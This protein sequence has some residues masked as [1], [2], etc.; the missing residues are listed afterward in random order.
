VRILLTTDAMGGVWDHATTLYGRLAE[1]GHDVFLAVLGRPSGERT[2]GLPAGAR[3]AA[4]SFALE[5]A[6]GGIQDIEPAARWIASL[7]D[8]MEADV[9]HLNQ[10]AYAHRIERPT[11]VAVHSDAWSWFS[12]IRGVPPRHEPRWQ[13][14]HSAVARG[15]AAAAA[16][17]AP[18][19]YQADRVERHYGRAVD[20]VIRNGLD[21]QTLAD[22]HR[23][24]NGDE[25]AQARRLVTLGRA[26]DEA[27]GHRTVDEALGLVRQPWSA[28]L[29]GD[30]EGPDG[31]RLH[32]KRLRY[33]G[34]LPI[35]DARE[36]LRRTTVYVAAS[37]YEPFGLAPV[38]AAMA[39]CAL[40]LSDIGSFRELWGNDALFFA[41]GNAAAL[42]SVLDRLHGDRSLHHQMRLQ[43]MRRA[44]ACFDDRRMTTEYTEVY[45]A[46]RRRFGLSCSPAPGS[47]AS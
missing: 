32:P 3:W 37:L 23:F 46:V 21:R 9:V 35:R 11:V 5:W 43:A 30:I 34:R 26:W 12:E 16:V 27:K 10:L 42:A 45:K 4:R 33:L 15:L 7:A 40:V 13:A 1:R 44:W 8:A 36:L 18:S 19:Q 31:Q 39:G 24:A 47:A 28:Y 29:A 6:E 17:V 25:S 2:A 41:P 38:E 14:Y 22:G 20:R